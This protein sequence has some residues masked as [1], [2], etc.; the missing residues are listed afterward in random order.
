MLEDRK[1]FFS[2]RG[3]ENSIFTGESH[4]FVGLEMR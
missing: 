1:S 2:S 4:Y 3:H